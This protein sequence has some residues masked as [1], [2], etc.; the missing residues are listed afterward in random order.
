MAYGRYYTW[1]AAAVAVILV[2]ALFYALSKQ[3]DKAHAV[4]AADAPHATVDGLEQPHGA[5]YHM[6]SEQYKKAV[7]NNGMHA[8]G[9]G[10]GGRAETASYKECCG[11]HSG[12]GIN[13]QEGT[14]AEPKGCYGCHTKSGHD[15]AAPTLAWAYD[16]RNGYDVYGVPVCKDT[17]R[18]GADHLDVVDIENW[19]FYNGEQ[20]TVAPS[21]LNCKLY[22]LYT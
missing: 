15:G 5:E 17:E 3:A 14:D 22:K 11:K 2:L 18:H 9:Y 7:C 8:D 1:G 12:S 13:H 16:D 19:L 10:G 4:A 20:Y 21:S 6:N